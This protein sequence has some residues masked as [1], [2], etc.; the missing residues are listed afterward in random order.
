[1]NPRIKLLN[2]LL[3]LGLALGAV[4]APSVS[5]AAAG[6]G[7]ITCD[8]DGTLV[9]TGDF[10]TLSLSTLAGAVVYTK[11]TKGA[12]AIASGSTFV[13]HV[14]GN[15][16]LRIGGGSMTAKGV[17]GIKLT[18]SGANAHL[19]ATGAGKLVVRGEGECVTESGQTYTWKSNKDTTVDVIQ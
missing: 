9:F 2:G 17:K 4:G 11:P 8:G 19:E 3:V 16:T 14:A 6:T 7:K 13:K 5:A 1:M 18:L 15:T 12:L 10:A